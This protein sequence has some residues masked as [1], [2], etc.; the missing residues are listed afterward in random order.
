MVPVM[1]ES[2]ERRPGLFAQLEL[3]LHLI[4]CTW[5]VRYLKQIELMREVSVNATD[6]MPPAALNAEA[7]QRIAGA[8][9]HEVILATNPH[10]PTRIDQIFL[11]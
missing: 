5:C 7:R 8:L 1:S 4:V 11:V 9:R 6:H 2:M 3:K 10:G